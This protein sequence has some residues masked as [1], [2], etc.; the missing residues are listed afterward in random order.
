MKRNILITGGAGFIGTHLVKR[1]LSLGWEVTVIDN[2]ST[3]DLD[4]IKD[5]GCK[6][7]EE[8]IHN[9]IIQTWELPHDALFHLAAPVSVEESLSNP[10]KYY[11]EIVGGTTN[12]V[13][14]SLKQGNR[15]IIIHTVF[16]FTFSIGISDIYHK[17]K[18][19]GGLPSLSLCCYSQTIVPKK[20]FN[21]ISHFWPSLFFMFEV[22]AWHLLARFCIRSGISFV[23]L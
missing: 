23:C 2:L 1:L 16:L 19:N 7:I 11:D 13:D 22:F 21:S 12:I 4:N 5:L 17:Q 15:N 9:P 14:W 8:H 20:L 18:N 10:S 3:G 6:F